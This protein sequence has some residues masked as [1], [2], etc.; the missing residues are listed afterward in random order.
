MMNKAELER[1]AAQM[2]EGVRLVSSEPVKGDTG[3]EGAK[4]IFAFDDINKVQVSQGPSMSGGTG[5]RAIVGADVD[6]PVRFKLTRSG[7]TSTLTHQLHRSSPAAARPT[8]AE[9]AAR[10]TCRT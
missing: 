5:T 2:G 10:P 3:F 8:D 4:A 7:G 9:P 1:T 6:D